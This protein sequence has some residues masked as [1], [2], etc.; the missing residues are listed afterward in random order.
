MRSMLTF[1]LRGSIFYLFVFAFCVPFLKHLRC[2]LHKF[3]SM[4]GRRPCCLCHLSFISMYVQ[5]LGRFLHHISI[6]SIIFDPTN[7]LI[8]QATM[9]AKH[10]SLPTEVLFQI[11]VSRRL[12]KE[13][14]AVLPAQTNAFTA[15][16]HRHSTIQP[17]SRILP[18]T[19]IVLQTTTDRTSESHCRQYHPQMCSS[20]S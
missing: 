17:S 18:S 1:I 5:S 4:P 13:S 10:A 12:G 16:L 15:G 7:T 14:C 2:N 3:M 9:S 20:L 6:S 11:L 19:A 8:K